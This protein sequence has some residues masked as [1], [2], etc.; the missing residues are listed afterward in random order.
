MKADLLGGGAE[1]VAVL[2]K[3]GEEFFGFVLGAGEVGIEVNQRC[4]DQKTAIFYR[5]PILQRHK[6]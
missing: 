2:F 5:L 4:A 3:A 6:N 1:G